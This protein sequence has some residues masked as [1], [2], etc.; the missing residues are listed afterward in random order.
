MPSSYSSLYLHLIFSTKNREHWLT[1]DIEERVWQ[2]LGAIARE[3]G[4]SPIQIGGVDDHVHALVGCPSTMSASRA[5]QLLKGASSRWI[6]STFPDLAGFAWQDSYG[7]FS[8]SQSSLS[9]VADYIRGQ[10][11]HHQKQSFADEL[12][13][14]LR[15]H[16]IDANQ[17]DLTE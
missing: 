16:G 6:H 13:S 5:A 1:C 15:E 4:M 3:R 17:G 9:T 2:Y 12:R 7:A 11:Q 10:R 8:V 14:V